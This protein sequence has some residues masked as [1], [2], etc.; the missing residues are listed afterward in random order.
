MRRLKQVC[1]KNRIRIRD[2][3]QVSQLCTLPA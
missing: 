3:L 1:Y 2:F